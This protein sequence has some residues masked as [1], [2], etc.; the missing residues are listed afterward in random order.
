[1]LND[2]EPHDG[3]MTLLL[4]SESIGHVAGDYLA[5]LG[6]RKIAVIRAFDTVQRKPFEHELRGMQRAFAAFPDVRLRIVDWPEGYNRPSLDHAGHFMDRLLALSP[7][8]TGLYAYSDDY[9]F[10]ILAAAK[11]SGLRI[12]Q[13]LSVLG[14]GNAEFSQLV[15]PS[16]T[17]IT[18]DASDLGGR[19]VALINSL[20]TGVPAE[21][22][23]LEPPE[24]AIV[25]REST[26]QHHDPTP[27]A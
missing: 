15:Q 13:D 27:A 16:L 22:R 1:M 2:I 10:T 7:R 25:E 21:Q 24:P 19:A 6:H 9:A 18:V 4:P 23:F 3:V 26:K 11:K 17:T 20:I 5:R 14:T 12:P 8:P